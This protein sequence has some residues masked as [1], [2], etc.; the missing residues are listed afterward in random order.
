MNQPVAYNSVAVWRT[1]I[2]VA[3]LV[4][5]SN[6]LP[7][8]ILV[9][10][11]AYLVG[12]LP[13]SR[14]V[15]Q[16]AAAMWCVTAF[17]YTSNDYFDVQEDS[18]N[19]P[20]RPLPASVVSARATAWLAAGLALSAIGFSWPIGGL[21]TGVACI[22]LGLLTLYN[23]RL[24]ATPGGGNLLIALL[25]GCTLLVGGVAARGF[26]RQAIEPLLA[27]FSI[28]AA[29]V[30]TREI[31]KTLEDIAGDRMAGKQTIATRL[32]ER[33]VTRMLA[34]LNIVTILLSLVPFIWL[35]YSSAYLGVISLGVSVP[36]VFTTVYLWQDA[37]P[38]RV[39]RCLALLKGSYFAGLVA[40]LL[41]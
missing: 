13:L 30:A 18:I 35:G 38:Q 4:R 33:R 17:G 34:L 6:S 32:G 37:S 26:N 24:K 3:R 11:G 40:L 21:A 7:A 1:A 23:T 41:A 9:L 29:F 28:L 20:D 25:A 2:G 5:F 22:V 14:A 31:L 12:G 36:L 19:K 8:S 39:S 16:A 15:W 27:P 10:I